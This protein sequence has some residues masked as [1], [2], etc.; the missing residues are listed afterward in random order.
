M[1]LPHTPL[2]FGILNCEKRIWRETEFRDLD[3]VERGTVGKETLGNL[4][5]LQGRYTEAY[6][7]SCPKQFPIN[8]F[9]PGN[10][11]T[12]LELKAALEGVSPKLPPRVCHLQKVADVTWMEGARLDF[13]SAAARLVQPVCHKRAAI[14]LF[15]FREGKESLSQRISLIFKTNRAFSIGELEGP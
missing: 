13:M 2:K 1:K 6:L 7:T 9:A 10:F 4:S 14:K 3:T 5:R 8:T 11:S 15:D 12:S